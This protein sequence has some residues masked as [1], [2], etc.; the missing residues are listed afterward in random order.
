MNF[1]EA[2]YLRAITSE[3]QTLRVLWLIEAGEMDEARASPREGCRG[4]GGIFTELKD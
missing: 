3:T 4:I 2:F 1:Q